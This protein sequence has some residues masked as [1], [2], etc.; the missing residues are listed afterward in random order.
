MDKFT[1]TQENSEVETELRLITNITIFNE[2]IKFV[3]I[4]QTISNQLKYKL[5]Y[6]TQGVHRQASRVHQHIMCIWD[7]TGCRTYKALNKKLNEMIKQLEMFKF[8]DIKTTFTYSNGVKSNPKNLYTE[9]CMMYPYKEYENDVNIDLDKQYGYSKDHIFNMRKIANEEWKRKLAKE[10]KA[11]HE[12]QLK[13]CKKKSLWDYL[14]QHT[15]HML[16]TS[17]YANDKVRETARLI[18]RYK[19]ME[20]EEFRIHDLKNQAVN[21]L[22]KYKKLTEDEVLDIANI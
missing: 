16:T 5:L 20:D 17:M 4:I 13:I 2:D 9:S 15:Q 19:S 18:L 8:I 1:P 21:Y 3:P 12:K 10:A 14:E 6:T 7:C 22:Y 11:E